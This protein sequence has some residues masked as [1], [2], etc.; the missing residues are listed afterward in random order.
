M[1]AINSTTQF[2]QE[3]LK[4]LT[5][6]LQEDFLKVSHFMAL[7]FRFALCDHILIV[8]T[9]KRQKRKEKEKERERE[10]NQIHPE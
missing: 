3:Q 10:N 2:L 9:I 6:H 8:L 4:P 7:L 5:D 1:F